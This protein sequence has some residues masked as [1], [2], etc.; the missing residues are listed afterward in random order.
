METVTPAGLVPG[1]GPAPD[2]TGPDTTPAGLAPGAVIE[3]RH[4]PP[5]AGLVVMAL[6]GI[7]LAAVAGTA[8][9]VFTRWFTVAF[10]QDR[11]LA[12]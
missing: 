5:V 3:D 1:D 6:A 7:G 12:L 4:V 11:R 10:P 2:V 8:A 9:H